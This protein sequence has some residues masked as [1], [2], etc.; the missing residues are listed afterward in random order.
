[1]GEVVDLFTNITMTAHGDTKDIL[2]RTYEYCLGQF[3]E[4]E[5]KLAGEFYTPACECGHWLR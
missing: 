5:G 2:G 3:A 1:L 4:Q